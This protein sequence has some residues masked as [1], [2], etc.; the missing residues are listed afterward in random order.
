M[1]IDDVVDAF[2]KCLKFDDSGYHCF[3]IGTGTPTTV[4]DIIDE[5]KKYF[6]DDLEVVFEKSTPGDMHGIYADTNLALE[7]LKWKSQISFSE[8]LAKMLHWLKL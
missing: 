8:G 4:N 2:Y 7:K 6:D 1:Y 3:N 5:I